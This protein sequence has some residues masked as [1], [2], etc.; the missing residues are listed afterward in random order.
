LKTQKI[1]II[2]IDDLDNIHIDRVCKLLQPWAKEQKVRAVV[3]NRKVQTLSLEQV[4]RV[5][6]LI[7]MPPALEVAL[8]G[9]PYI[10]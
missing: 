9:I 4:K 7:T 5:V 6:R 3:I 2:Q 1:V 10:G 8:A